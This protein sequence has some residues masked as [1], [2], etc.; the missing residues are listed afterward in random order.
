MLKYI[1][2]KIFGIKPK[3][4]YQ[5]L[6]QHEIEAL[7]LEYNLADAHT[8]QSQSSS[9]RKIIDRLPSLWYEA[10]NTKQYDMEQRFIKTFFRAQGQYYALKP[11]NAL[12]VYAAS[13]AMAIVANYLMKKKMSVSLMEP[14]FDNIHDLL[15][16]MQIKI[17]PLKEEWLYDPS[18][19][20]KTLN[21]HVKSDAIFI[22]DPNNPTGFTLF[23]YDKTAYRELIRFAKDKKKLLI[24]DFCFASFML[25]DRNLD[26]FDLYEMLEKS[27]VTYI[28][29]EDTGKTWPVQDTKTALIKTSRNI[30][31]DVYNIQTS[32]LLN[33]SPFILNLLTQ[34]IVDSKKDKFASVYDLLERNRKIAKKELSGSLLEYQEPKS[35][36]S[37]AWFKI[38]NPKFKATYLQQAI[39]KEG[40]Y[41]LPG[42]YF[43]WDDRSQGEQFIRIALARNTEMFK[44]AIQLVRRALDKVTESQ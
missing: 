36:V 6:T 28:S 17:E 26:V 19:I 29:I 21:K 44:P 10:E 41:V 15:A 3:K 18:K 13:I 23:A 2:E 38:T 22:V 4:E 27:G 39:L 20:Y 12:L 40:V 43:F 16:N 24:F 11:N 34:Y 30:W 42:T 5:D 8:H 31:Q 9:Q 35:K 7:K 32:Y 33:V 25:P 14:C 37:V 1:K